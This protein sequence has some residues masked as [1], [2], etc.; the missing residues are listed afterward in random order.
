MFEPGFDQ[1]AGLRGETP[2]GG[3]VL[4]PVA[5]PAQ[6]AR[7]Y[8]WLCT[9]AASLTAEGRV[10]V[11]VDGTATEATSRDR[12]D[13]AHLGLMRV[14]QDPSIAQLERPTA[15]ADW[16]VMPGAAG[17]QT[18]QD[19]AHA[20][21][22]QIAVSR[23]LAPFASG[24]VVLLFAPALALGE[25]LCGTGAHALV[26]V[27]EQPHSTIDAYGAV[28][29]LD[30]AGL[31]PV[32][33]PLMDQSAAALQTIVNTVVDTAQ[34][35]LNLPLDCWPVATWALRVQESAV[36]RPRPTH[37]QGHGYHGLLPRAAVATHAYTAAAAVAP[38]L[39]S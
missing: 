27:I 8:E 16:L 38:S 15:G 26:P 39:W 11:I 28:K 7:A 37:A 6:P 31:S 23:L 1:A 34:R 17:L 14:L 3:P 32:L 9:L 35:H 12:H 24:V 30:A 21:G 36:A 13:G 18:L 5:S 33:A 25:L 4:M 29:V 2:E 19:T 10:V 22:S 20:A